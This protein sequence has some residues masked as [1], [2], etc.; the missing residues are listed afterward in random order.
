MSIFQAV[1]PITDPGMPAD[2][3]FEEALQDLPNVAS[4]HRARITGEPRFEI[5]PGK[6][7]PGCQGAA[8]VVTCTAPAVLVPHSVY[9]RP[10]GLAA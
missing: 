8:Y 6:R 9:G 5:R 10:E 4:R 3:L 1:W 7:V 2:L